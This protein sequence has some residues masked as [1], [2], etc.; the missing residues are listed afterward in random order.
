MFPAIVITDPHLHERMPRLRVEEF[1]ILMRKLRIISVKRRIET[2]I[3]MG[4][5]YDRN[6]LV[7]IREI[8]RIASF[9]SIFKQ[10]ARFCT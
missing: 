5:L 7:S 3:I 2:L 6:T 8:M 10:V 9:F 4:D 1:D